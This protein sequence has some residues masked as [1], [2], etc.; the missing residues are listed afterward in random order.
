MFLILRAAEVT[1]RASPA[2]TAE[3][4]WKC[5]QVPSAFSKIYFN[6]IGTIVSEQSPARLSLSS[7][8]PASD[9]AEGNEETPWQKAAP[10]SD[11]RQL[12]P[13]SSHFI[14]VSF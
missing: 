5:E 7:A 11:L 1:I 13:S 8:A 9:A 6:D 3:H 10:L 14:A 12:L 2:L 4:P